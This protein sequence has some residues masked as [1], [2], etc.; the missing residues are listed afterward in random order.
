MVAAG[1]AARA[2]EGAFL[3]VKEDPA[4]PRV[5]KGTVK[6]VSRYF[7]IRRAEPGE[8]LIVTNPAYM[9]TPFNK[10]RYT[11][12]VRI[13]KV[14]GA[15]RVEAVVAKDALMSS[16]TATRQTGL[17]TDKWRPAGQDRAFAGKIIDEIIEETGAVVSWTADK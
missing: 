10:Y 6:V 13:F 1:C 14:A 7:G 15:Y 17:P 2:P 9:S 8:G 3:T 4:Y 12:T 11:A 16:M 5:W